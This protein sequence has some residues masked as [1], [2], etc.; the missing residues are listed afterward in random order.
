M[1]GLELSVEI[2]FNVAMHNSAPTLLRASEPAEAPAALTTRVLLEAIAKRLCVEP[3]YNKQTVRL[4]P[5]IVYTRHGELHVDGVTA[6]R[7]GKAPREVK[8]GTFKLSGLHATGLTK[9]LFV[10]HRDFDAGQEKYAGVTIF[11]LGD[12]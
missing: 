6:A 3:T 9:R 5:H 4:A 7:D 11:A 2:Y 12:D 8:L 1:L 10:P